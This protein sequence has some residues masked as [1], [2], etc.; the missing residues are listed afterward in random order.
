MHLERHF[1]YHKEEKEDR[2]PQSISHR[3]VRKKKNISLITL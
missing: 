1:L 3:P 2:N